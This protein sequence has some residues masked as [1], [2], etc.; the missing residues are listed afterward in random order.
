MEPVAGP[1]E[2]GAATAGAQERLLVSLAAL[3]ATAALFLFR[4]ADDNRLV[5][6]RWVFAD[7]DPVRLYALSAAGIALAILLARFPVPRRR[8]GAILFAA[9]YAAGALFWR[10]PE[11]AVDASRYFTQAKHLEIHGLGYFL[12]EWGRDI[13]AWTDLPLVPLLHGLAFRL[14]GESRAAIQALSTLL[15][16]GSVALTHRLGRSLWDGETGFTAGALLLAMPYLLTQ[17]PAMLVDVP[18]M[19]FLL[20]AVVAVEAAFRRGGRG[21]ILLASLAVTLACFSKYSAFLFLTV[22]PL[23][24][25]VRRNGPRPLRTG[26]WVALLAAALVL[27]AALPRLEVHRDQIALLLAYQAPGLRRWGESLASTF[28]FQVHPFVTAAALLSAWVAIGR[29]DARYAVV[30]WPVLLLLLLRVQRI[31][32]LLPAFPMVALMAAYGLQRI[33]TPEVRRLVAGCA[34]ATSLVVALSG[35]LPFLRGTGAGNLKAAGEYLDALGEARVEVLTLS[36][37][38]AEVNPAVWV[39]L[40]DL[41]TGKPLSYAY[42]GAP[43]AARERARASP[44]RFTWEYRNPDWYQGGDH[45]GDAAV[46]LLAYDLDAPRPPEVEARLR[47]LRPARTFVADD[48]VFRDRPLVA[49][50][51]AGSEGEEAAGRRPAAAPPTTSRSPGRPRRCWRRAWRSPPGPWRARPRCCSRP[52]RPP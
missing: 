4:A 20:L 15:F 39:P 11:V 36:R 46:V 17:V 51:R 3:G 26:L 24:G 44:L 22:L 7:S 42:P 37:P 43:A 14:F 52:G 38:D 35:H 18:T 5:S 8:A 27:S 47:G 19:F 30:L 33:R 28:L 12:A 21:R 41:H 32:Y 49:V 45:G 50:Y 16:A 6:W 34:V 40:L 31:R 13:P 48:G 9:S 2:P 10:A 29:R 25:V 23:I 1:V